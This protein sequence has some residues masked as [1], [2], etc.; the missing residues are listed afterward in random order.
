MIPKKASGKLIKYNFQNMKIGK[1][2]IVA[3]DYNHAKSIR[4]CALK[5]GYNACI[6]TVDNEVRV[7]LVDDNNHE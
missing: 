7:Y 6:R 3:N 1:D 2:W 5:R 4:I